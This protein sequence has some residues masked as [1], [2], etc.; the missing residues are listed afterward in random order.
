MASLTDDTA[1]AVINALFRGGTLSPP[2]TYYA[3]LFTTS[4][5]DDGTGGVE[6]TGTG[7]SRV[8]IA[9]ASGSFTDPGST[10][11]TTNAIAIEFPAIEGAWGNVVAIAIMDA[12]TGGNVVMKG[13]VSPSKVV[14]LGQNPVQFAVGDL[15]FSL[16]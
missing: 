8:E 4:P 5:G 6:V 1:A 15:Q 12:S 14:T 16:V 9:N 7:Y 3:A 13:A 11:T 10:R 2:A